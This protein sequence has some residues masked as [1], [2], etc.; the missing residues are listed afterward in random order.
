METENL[1]KRIEACAIKHGIDYEHLKWRARR[2]VEQDRMDREHHLKMRQHYDEMQALF[3]LEKLSNRAE[4]V[5]NQMLAEQARWLAESLRPGASVPP[6]PQ[7]A[8]IGS[9]L[10]GSLLGLE[11]PGAVSPLI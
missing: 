4:N 2:R 8:Q 6:P 1:A 10:F 5:R 7:Y 9:N 3:G 11:P